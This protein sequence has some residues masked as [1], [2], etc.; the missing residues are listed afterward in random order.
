MPRR[1]RLTVVPALLAAAFGSMIV[2]S[3]PAAA[4]PGQR[5]VASCRAELLSRFPEGAMR[6]HRIVDISGNSRRTRVT[7]SVVADRRYTF[8][9][10]AD[11]EG[12]ILVASFDPPRA[13][14]ALAAG[15]R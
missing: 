14:N 11:G 8:E 9:C 6:S 13:D 4:D 7:M 12:R 10:A 1:H 2:A 15:Q 5:A 3:S